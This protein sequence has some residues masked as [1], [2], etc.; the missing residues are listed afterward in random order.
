VRD[1]Q[2]PIVDLV[3]GARPNF[4]KLAP[5]VRALERHRLFAARIVHTGQHYDSQMDDALFEELR[6][7]RPDVRLEA[8]SGPTG[9]KPRGFWNATKRT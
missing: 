8:G 1:L 3:A 4:V 9:R 5:V 7:P 6:I 2:Q